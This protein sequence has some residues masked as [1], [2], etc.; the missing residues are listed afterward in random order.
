MIFIKKI[1]NIQF[2]ISKF[3]INNYLENIKKLYFVKM[4]NNNLN[5]LN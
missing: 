2:E 1:N 5:K 4:F 3:F